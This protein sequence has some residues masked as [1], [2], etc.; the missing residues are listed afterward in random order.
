MGSWKS[1]IGR[2]LANNLNMA[3]IDTDDIIEQICD[4]YGNLDIGTVCK[5]FLHKDPVKRMKIKE[6]QF[7]LNKP[8]KLCINR[9]WTR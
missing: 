4:D 9:P 6:A 1:T 3:F 7:F 5:G 8:L 2:T